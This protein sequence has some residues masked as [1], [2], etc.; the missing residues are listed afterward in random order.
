MQRHL[1]TIKS[2][3]SEVV[4]HTKT[5]DQPQAIQNDYSCAAESRQLGAA[6]TPGRWDCCAYVGATHCETGWSSTV[7]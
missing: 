1:Y 7:C 3:V 6:H 5:I 2:T 4:I